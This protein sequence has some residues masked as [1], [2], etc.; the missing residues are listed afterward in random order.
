MAWRGVLLYLLPLHHGLPFSTAIV[1][2]AA[3]KSRAL[4]KS[5]I[6]TASMCKCLE[7]IA[8]SRLLMKGSVAFNCKQKMHKQKKSLC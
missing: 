2:P 4:I 7:Y 8:L 3:D 6:K 1:S 5:H